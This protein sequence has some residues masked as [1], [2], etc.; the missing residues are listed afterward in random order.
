MRDYEV[1]TENWIENVELAE[2][3]KSCRTFLHHP[4]W[5][6]LHIQYHGYNPIV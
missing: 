2:H 1:V 4:I 6:P 5:C 3:L